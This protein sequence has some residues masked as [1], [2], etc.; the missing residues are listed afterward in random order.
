MSEPLSIEAA[1]Q[2]LT[3]PPPSEKPQRVRAAQVREDADIQAALAKPDEEEESPVEIE[4]PDADNAQPE[5]DDAEIDPQA[6]DDAAVEDGDGPE[7]EAAAAPAIEPPASWSAADKKTWAKLTPEVQAVVAKREADRDR[8]V[9]VANQEKGELTRVLTQVAERYQEQAPLLADQFSQRWGG[10]D[11]V[12]FARDDPDNCQVYRAEME[13]ERERL[14]RFNAET[15]RVSDLA[16]QRFLADEGEKL[17]SVAPDLADP[18]KGPDRRRRVAEFLVKQGFEPERLRYA[19][20]A[21]LSIAQDA[22][23]WREAQADAQRRASLPKKQPAAAPPPK[24]IASNGAGTA[25]PPQ[26]ALQGL[27][28]KLTKSGSLD[29]AVSLLLARQTQASK[30]NRR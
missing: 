24:P 21:E 25:A 18:D 14:D 5:G 26:R 1:T 29:D 8:A 30:G 10:I 4:E 19:T 28:T 23:K 20:A 22:M 2:A 27:E 6:D 16:Y 12:K 9:S 17:R 13:A 11:W 15:K 3:A 7:E